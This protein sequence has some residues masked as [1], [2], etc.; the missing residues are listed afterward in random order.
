MLNISNSNT[1]NSKLNDDVIDIWQIPIK[2]KSFKNRHLQSL[3]AHEL[4]RYHRFYFDIHKCRFALSHHATRH[5]L[6]LY[7]DCLPK[8]I[9]F[10]SSSHGKPHVTNQTIEFNLSHSGH[11]AF[12]A[13]G[14]SGPLGIDVECYKPR[15]YLGLARH[16][17][18]SAE[19][20]LLENLTAEKLKMSFFHIWAQKEALIKAMGLG[21]SY[22]T[23]SFTVTAAP[24]AN[25]KDCDKSFKDAYAMISFKAD[26]ESQVALCYPKNTIKIQ[27]IDYEILDQH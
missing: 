15:D 24:P 18:S 19:V 13:V 11:W 21:L 12:L 16:A 9:E 17:F 26:N 4:E 3:N 27:K 1:P 14:T 25:I 22:P 6:S 5:I 10:F 8:D 23:K 2:E 7:C 20:K